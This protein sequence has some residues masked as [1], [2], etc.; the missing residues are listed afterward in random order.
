MEIKTRLG[1]N[2]EPIIFRVLRTSLGDC[3]KGKLENTVSQA[4]FLISVKF[5]YVG[6]LC[7]G[8]LGLDLQYSLLIRS[9]L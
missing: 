5:D 2:R 7:D 9:I 4:D 6:L 3:S 8:E 1:N